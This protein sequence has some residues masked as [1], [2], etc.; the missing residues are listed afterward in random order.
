[1]Q[2]RESAVLLAQAV[3]GLLAVLDGDPD[4]VGELGDAQ[5]PTGAGQDIADLAV[6]LIWRQ[7]LLAG[8]GVAELHEVQL[9][10]LL[11]QVDAVALRDLLH[12]GALLGRGQLG[13]QCPDGLHSSS[14]IDRPA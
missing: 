13:L 14:A 1:M 12:V 10:Q 8:G 2:P 4:L 3:G 11:D 5:P 9:D 6:E 7:P